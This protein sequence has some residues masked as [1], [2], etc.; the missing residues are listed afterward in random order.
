MK[1]SQIN[2]KI[3]LSELEFEKLSKLEAILDKSRKRKSS[4]KELGERERSDQIRRD[5]EA[6]VELESE[7]NAHRVSKEDEENFVRIAKLDCKTKKGDYHF[8]ILDQT[9]SQEYWVDR[10]RF[11]WEEQLQDAVI[12]TQ[13]KRDLARKGG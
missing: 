9:A 3:G 8:R 2:E 10:G 11:L 7:I 5:V 12:E 4:V 6:G 1:T 13:I